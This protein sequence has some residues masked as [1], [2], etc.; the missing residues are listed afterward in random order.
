MAVATNTQTVALQL[1]K[2]RDKLPLLYERD[3]ILLTLIEQKG[4]VENVST[5][6]MRV[7][8]QIRPG[9]QFAQASMD[10]ADL[11]VGSGTTTDVAV[12]SPIFFTHAVEISKLV[13][14]ATTGRE[15]AIED[16]S[17]R[18][19]VNAMKQFRMALDVMCNTNGSGVIDTVGSTYS[20]GTTF[21][22]SNA[23][24][25]FYNNTYQVYS[26][27]LATNRGSFTVSS[28]DPFAKTIV[29][30][31]APSGTVAG[32]VLV[33]NG[34]SGA[35]P[36]SL[37]GL[38][39]HHVDSS[40]GSWLGLTRSTYPEALKTPHVAASNSALVPSFVRL[41]QNKLR[42]A[43]GTAANEK[44]VAYC[45]LDQEA[46]WESLATSISEVIINQVPE[47]SMPDVFR[48]GPPKTMGGIPIKSSI[49]ANP[50]RIDFV[51][52]SHW[53]RAVLKEIDF[54]EI[55]GQTIFPVYGTSGGLQSAYLFY[56]VVGFQLWMDGPR[57]GAFI[58]GL[59]LPTGY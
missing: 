55:G 13:E 9:G 38:L 26:S 58:D 21:P 45:N 46:A 49:H 17:K 18:E 28:V 40:S 5:R 27:N 3:D 48:K 19:I 41:A 37:F 23:D 34:V 14:Y 16:W 15:R 43:L 6:N 47:G 11:G 52:L 31:A 1:E 50:G 30:S 39:Y 25:F 8:L 54:F 10:N 42:K 20:S 51:A 22:V 35:S 44:I 12:L 33:V 2:V 32:D 24:S 36:S 53:G 29:V 7:P 57:F 56:Y 59:S 4:D